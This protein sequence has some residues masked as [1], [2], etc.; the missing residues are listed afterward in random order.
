MRQ[1]KEDL[2]QYTEIQQTSTTSAVT[3]KVYSKSGASSPT[4]NYD[5]NKIFMIAMEIKG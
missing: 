1:M 3:Y 5:T 2:E 4:F